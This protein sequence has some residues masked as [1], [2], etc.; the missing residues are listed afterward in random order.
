MC[1]CPPGRH[2]K[3]SA[4]EECGEC[5]TGALPGVIA[6]LV[7]DFT[8]LSIIE[9][10]RCPQCKNKVHFDVNSGEE[11]EYCEAHLSYQ[12]SCNHDPFDNQDSE[13]DTTEIPS[14]TVSTLSPPQTVPALQVPIPPSLS[15]QSNTSDGIQVCAIPECNKPRHVD[16]KGTVHECCGYRH[17]MELIRRKEIKRKYVAN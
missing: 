15:I 13:D 8:D 5:Q 10:T 7:T 12:D 11:F 17:A 14:L 2:I 16:D 6:D 1:G 4:I 9:A 3:A